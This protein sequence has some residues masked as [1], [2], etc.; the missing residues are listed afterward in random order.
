MAS[1][2]RLPVSY[3]TST[4]G[5]AGLGRDYTVLAT[6][7]AAT[8][9]N[10]VTATM[11]EVLECY[12][13]ADFTDN[14][15]LAGAITSSSYFR[16][17]KPASGQGHNGT[18]TVGVNFTRSDGD[19]LKISEHNGQIQDIIAFA[20]STTINTQCFV[21]TS[22]C[23]YCWFV[24]CI[25]KITT[26]SNQAFIIQNLLSGAVN[27]LAYESA[28]G[29]RS[30]FSGVGAK[31]YNCTA[32]GCGTGFEATAGAPIA[33]NCVAE[34]NTT[35]W[36]GT[37]TKTTCTDEDGVVF[38]NTATDDYH[39]DSTDTAAKDQGTDLSAD[40]TYAFDDDIDGDTR[41]GSWDI[42]F[43]ENLSAGSSGN[44]NYYYNQQ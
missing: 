1:S 39:L 12:D 11:G 13:D 38:V 44:P 7:E 31:F 8:D 5:G 2:R 20:T 24:G 37:W 36:F 25:G 34:G 22:G 4:Y 23:Q 35:N 6:W 30:N 43:D 17:I 26:S 18:P 9:I 21:V 16:V 10:L 40:A 32:Y 19:T 42:G 41:S 15:E 29:F 27:C 33:K 3:N 28:I 14:V